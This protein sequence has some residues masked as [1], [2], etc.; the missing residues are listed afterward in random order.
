MPLAGPLKRHCPLRAEHCKDL[1]ETRGLLRY[2]T[3]L[4]LSN[5]DKTIY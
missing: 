1:V 3:K 4:P 5:S 2:I